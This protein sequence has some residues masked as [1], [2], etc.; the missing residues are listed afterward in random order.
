MTDYNLELSDAER[1]GSLVAHIFDDWDIGSDNKYGS[2]IKPFYNQYGSGTEI[3]IKLENLPK[4]IRDILRELYA[5]NY[6]GFYQ[7]SNT[8]DKAIMDYIQAFNNK[9]RES[10]NNKYIKFI[11][12]TRG[13]E[14]IQMPWTDELMLKNNEYITLYL[15]KFMV[16]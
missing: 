15:Y 12:E 5:K 9:F 4:N 2:T 6:I 16:N 3:V 8:N 13:L 14:G 1:Y 7:A 11:I 10:T